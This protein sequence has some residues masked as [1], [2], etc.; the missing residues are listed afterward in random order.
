MSAPSAAAPR[1]IPW[2]ALGIAA[3]VVIVAAM[4]LDASWRSDKAPRVTARP[5]FDPAAYGAKTYPKVVAA[6]DKRVVPV[7][8]LAPAIQDDPDAA[9][10]KYGTRQGSSPY[11]FAVSGEGVAGEPESGLLPVRVRGAGDVQVNVQIGPAINGTALR[12][13]AGFITFDQ[14]INQVDYA[15]AATALNNQVKAKV[16]KGLGD[17][18]GKRVSFTGAFTFLAPSVVTVTPIR[19]QETG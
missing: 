6:I 9:G 4:A 10:K 3:I 8:E 13:A 12:D 11:N 1:Q 7:T 5:K 16:L 14:F 2:R 18:E 15:D 17:L 19:L